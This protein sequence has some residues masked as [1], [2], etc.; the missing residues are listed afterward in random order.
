M[1]PA[2]C[3]ST[4]SPESA[5]RGSGARHEPRSS[6]RRPGASSGDADHRRPHP[7]VHAALARAAARA[8]RAVQRP[9][10]AR[11]PRGDLPRRDAGRVPAARPLRLR[12][13]DR[14]DGRGRH[15]RLDRV[16]HLPQRVL[17][18]R[19][20]QQRGGP[21]IERHDGR[22]PAASTRTAS[23][24]SPRCPGSTRRA[25]STS[26]AGRATRARSASWSSPTSPAGA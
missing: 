26:S 4:E 13:A 7:H 2:C 15:R 11:R 5:T 20:R 8:R 3:R 12:P 18:R 23:A 1:S 22:G 19:G 25:R 10:P 24:G 14:G 6:R 21:R 16:A 17:G 9:D